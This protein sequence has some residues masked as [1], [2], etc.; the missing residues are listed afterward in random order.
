MNLSRAHA[1]WLPSAKLRMHQSPIR[2][3]R[4]EPPR[5]L[6]ST[7]V[8]DILARRGTS[9]ANPDKSGEF[10]SLACPGWAN[11]IALTPDRQ[12]VLIEQF[13]FGIEEITLEIPGGII[14]PGESPAEACAREL[15]EETG[16]TGDA[17]RMIGRVSANPAIQNN[18][19]HT[20][21]VLNARPAA[22]VNLDHLEE[23]NIRLT[24]LDEIPHLIR[25][26]AIHHAFVIAAFHHLSIAA[27]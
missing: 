26:G 16:Y 1:L 21:L 19:V 23:I 24:P 25:S 13:R 6:L 18:F 15:L 27:F 17:I 7:R 5:Q 14:D 3:W 20:G 11:V 10:F 4:L 8:F 9:A 22:A 12:V 2:P